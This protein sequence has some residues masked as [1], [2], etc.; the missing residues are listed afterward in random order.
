[1][2]DHSEEIDSL[3]DTY[4]KLTG[5]DIAMRFDRERNWLEFIRAGF[6][7]A[8]LEAV[9]NRILGLIK[10]G[11][12]RGEA[13]KFSN[14]IV[15]LDYFE[16]ELAMVKSEKALKPEQQPQA[17]PSVYN[18]KTILEAKRQEMN[19]LADRAASEDAFGLKWADPQ[20]HQKY[21]T[22]SKECVAIRRQ[23]GH[24]G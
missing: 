19:D 18:L 6:T 3:H 16:E 7:K 12:R 9:I 10:I 21:V 22:L 15:M 5:L 17:P 1:M 24:L 20:A 2:N 8:D 14:L 13:L 23:L 4:R 11:Q